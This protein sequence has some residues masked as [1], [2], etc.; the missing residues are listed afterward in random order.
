MSFNLLIVDDSSSMRNVLRKTVELS[1]FDVAEYFEA[2]N[3]QEALQVLEAEWVDLILCDIHMPVMDG[4][5]MLE[6]LH[7]DEILATTPVIMVTTEANQE[8][9]DY[10]LSLGARG[11]I[12][13]PFGP[14]QIRSFMEEVM[15]VSSD[16]GT[17]EGPDF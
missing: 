1:G 16:P 10:A 7:E 4:I 14:Q 2:S 11:C 3:G 6:E 17:L 15:G 5:S 9:L 12:R 13:K 8:R